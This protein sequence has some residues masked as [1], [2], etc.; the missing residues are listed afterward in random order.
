MLKLCRKFSASVASRLLLAVL[1]CALVLNGVAYLTHRHGSDEY[2][3]NLSQTELCG[4]CSNFGALGAAPE[5]AV[6][7]QVTWLLIGFAPVLL[8]TAPVL[9]R[10]VSSARPRAPPVS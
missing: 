7:G 9:R 2:R 8:L 3:G 4:L 6:A 1:L 5:V 10:F